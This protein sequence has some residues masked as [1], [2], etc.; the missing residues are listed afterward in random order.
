[1]ITYAILSIYIHNVH[2][3]IYMHNIHMILKS[4][5]ILEID[6]YWVT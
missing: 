4:V 1:M 2:V 6:S 3:D 5:G